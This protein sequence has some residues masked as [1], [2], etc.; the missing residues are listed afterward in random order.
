M[1]IG[2]GRV[3]RVSTDWKKWKSEI[4]KGC[5]LWMHIEVNDSIAIVTRYENIITENGLLNNTKIQ[6]CIS[7]KINIKSI[8]QTNAV[9][10]DVFDYT[11]NE[12]RNYIFLN[13]KYIVSNKISLLLI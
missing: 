12:T 13:T 8:K 1:K 3:D 2:I 4:W 7:T 9:F 6:F 11:N 5:Y 10:S